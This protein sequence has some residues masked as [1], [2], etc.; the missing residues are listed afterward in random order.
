MQFGNQERSYFKK[1][2]ERYIIFKFFLFILLNFYKLLD[3]D[4]TIK[5]VM[6]ITLDV[7][8]TAYI[9][10]IK[11]IKTFVNINLV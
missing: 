2:K 6:I 8:L 11:Y 1:K 7:V 3:I 4:Q 5:F 10:L 9:I